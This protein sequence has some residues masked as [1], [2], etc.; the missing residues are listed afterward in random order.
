MVQES[1]QD[2]REE[3]TGVRRVYRIKES[4]QDLGEF[5]GFGIVY[6]VQEKNLQGSG[7][8]TGCRR[9]Y[10]VQERIL[11]DLEKFTGFRRGSYRGQGSL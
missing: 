9:V 5:T 11:Q 8:F 1:L 7:E 4:L 3:L 6:R 10:R 2:S